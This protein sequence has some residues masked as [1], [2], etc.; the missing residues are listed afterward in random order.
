M[1][2][3]LS[4]IFVKCV[5]VWLRSYLKTINWSILKYINSSLIITNNVLVSGAILHLQ[6]DK[7]ILS[8]RAESVRQ[9]QHLGIRGVIFEFRIWGWTNFNIF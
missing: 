7:F 9:D 8:A 2:L 1:L 4:K 3:L 5:N 6:V